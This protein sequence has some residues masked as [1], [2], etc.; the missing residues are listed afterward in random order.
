[1]SALLEKAKAW[2]LNQLQAEPQPLGISA[3]LPNGYVEMAGRQLLD[4]CSWDF[5]GLASDI[6]VREA[7]HSALKRLGLQPAWGLRL[8]TELEQRMAAFW[9][10]EDAFYSALP[11]P[12]FYPLM[13]LAKNTWLAEP[14]AWPFLNP[15]PGLQGSCQTFLE[16]PPST[17]PALFLACG[18]SPFLGCLPPLPQLLQKLRPHKG[19]LCVDESLSIGLLGN[20]GKG[21]D[22]HFL[23]PPGQTWKV[24]D[25]GQALGA[26][27]FVFG[28]PKAVVS[29]LRQHPLGLQ[30]AWGQAPN[31][32]AALRALHLL[33]TET[34]RRE[35]LWEIALRLHQA[36][37]DG[38][39]DVGPS[40]SPLLPLWAGNE[41]KLETLSQ[42]LQKSGLWLREY[43]HGRNSYFILCPKAT[44][45]DEA[46]QH[47][48]EILQNVAHKHKWNGQGLALEERGTA[49]SGPTPTPTPSPSPPSAFYLAHSH[50]SVLANNAAHH[51]TAPSVASPLPYAPPK[52]HLRSLFQQ[53]GTSAFMEELI[54]QLVNLNK[55]TL[56]QKAADW[57]LKRLQR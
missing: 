14:P 2:N 27:G 33:E 21:M 13:K 39:F 15:L 7:A 51:W 38:G 35:R 12:I 47:A 9:G 45:S 19:C 11:S 6:R 48:M 29:F 44:H 53:A 3:F 41:M 57:V 30:H 8:Q 34:W 52:T 18:I 25:L 17:A 28:G 5:L 24:C 55:P 22:E 32:S 1:M 26:Q 10:T 54:W 46:L 49:P 56:R 16:A 40:V 42:A 37:R 4:A 50:P 20:N 31:L 43:P 36:A 23:L